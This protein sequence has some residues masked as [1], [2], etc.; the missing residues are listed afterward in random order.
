M[1]VLEL[2][3]MLADYDGRLVVVGDMN[4]RADGSD[5][6]GGLAYHVLLQ[7]GLKDAWAALYPDALGYTSG[8]GD[9]L[10]RTTDPNT[11]EPLALYERI[12]YVLSRGSITPLAADVVGDTLADRLGGLWPS[13]HAGLV[14]TLRLVDARFL[15]P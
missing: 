5:A 12:D 14:A 9:E 15:E 3:G 6:D 2:V 8:W 10:W 7:A 1:Q 11:G 13:D 4:S